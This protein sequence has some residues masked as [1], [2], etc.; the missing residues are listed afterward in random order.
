MGMDPLPAALTTQR[1]S[2]AWEVRGLTLAPCDLPT[3]SF[4]ACTFVGDWRG[5]TFRGVR[6]WECDL[7]G[8]V[9]T[10]A[11]SPSDYN[12]ELLRLYRGSLITDLRGCTYDASTR[13]PAGIDQ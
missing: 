5:Y 8:A 12:P 1:A 6:L 2:R 11:D 13:W 10:N 7:S 3:S 9:L 4:T